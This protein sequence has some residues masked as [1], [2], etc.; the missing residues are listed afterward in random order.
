MN[1]LGIILALA[2]YV[3]DGW[4][5]FWTLSNM[6]LWYT[7]IVFIAVMAIAYFDFFLLILSSIDNEEVKNDAG[8]SKNIS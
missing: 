8:N 4:L 1:K 6:N 5:F 7:P 3:F 2:I